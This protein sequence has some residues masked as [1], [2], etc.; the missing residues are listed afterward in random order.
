MMIP[1]HEL[2]AGDVIPGWGHVLQAQ[3]KVEIIEVHT[4]QCGWQELAMVCDRDEMIS[5]RRPT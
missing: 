3:D 1:A 2:K 4:S 5:V